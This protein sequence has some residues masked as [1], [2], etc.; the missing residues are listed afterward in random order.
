MGKASRRSRICNRAHQ[1]VANVPRV[2]VQSNGAPRGRPRT[3]PRKLFLTKDMQAIVHVFLSARLIVAETTAVKARAKA[4]ALGPYTAD[5][6]R[7]FWLGTAAAIRWLDSTLNHA[8][9][10]LPPE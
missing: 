3:K 9:G 2:D 5:R 10:S 7:D 8:V 1:S 4:A 6:T